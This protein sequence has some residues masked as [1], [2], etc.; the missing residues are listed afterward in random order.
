MD[1]AEFI[2]C[3]L[4]LV[5]GSTE[6]DWRSAVSRMYYGA[7]HSACDLLAGCGVELPRHQAHA[8]LTQCLSQAANQSL[9]EASRKLSSLR[10]ARRIADYELRDPKP[11]NPQWAR[12]QIYHTQAVMAAIL[13]CSSAADFDKSAASIR[14]YARDTLRLTVREP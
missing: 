2:N 6:A 5:A 9:V 4:R 12:A 1:P 14:Q 11:Q 8:K 7:F 10:E 3:G 13:D